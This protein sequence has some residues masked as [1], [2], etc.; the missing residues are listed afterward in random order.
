M[1]EA[2]WQLTFSGNIESEEM[3]QRDADRW[4][5]RAKARLIEKE[6]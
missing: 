6:T 1:A 4:G 2:N 3:R 5:D